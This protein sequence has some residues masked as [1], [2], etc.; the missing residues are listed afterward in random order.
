MSN[1]SVLSFQVTFHFT[2]EQI[3]KFI[4]IVEQNGYKVLNVPAFVTKYI[5]K[6]I[7]CCGDLDMI[8]DDHYNGTGSGLEEVMDDEDKGMLYEVVEFE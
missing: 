8:W 4:Q 6:W 7:K 2:Q 3:D 1:T 5:H